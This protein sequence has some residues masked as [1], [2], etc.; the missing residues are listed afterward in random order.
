MSSVLKPVPTMSSLNVVAPASTVDGF[1]DVSFGA[2]TE[3][4]AR[5]MTFD[6][7]PFGAG[8][9]TLIGTLPIFETSEVKTCTLMCC[10]STMV[11]LRGVA[12]PM[13]TF[14]FATKFVPV[15]LSVND[16]AFCVTDVGE[17]AVIVGRFGL[18]IV[19]V[20]A[21]EIWLLGLATV[22]VSVPAVFTWVDVIC[23]VTC[24]ESTN[25]VACAVPFTRIAE[26]LTKFVPTTVSVNDAL[27]AL[28]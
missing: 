18:A 24:D 7:A 26:L 2:D 19:N 5:F 9:V 1:I 23:V 25:V 13:F 20:A 17:S 6:V 22:I 3:M 28:T 10:V 12:V 8:V 16:G 21:F 27:P 14:V 11:P 4:T 15:M